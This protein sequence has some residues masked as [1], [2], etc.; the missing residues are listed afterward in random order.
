[1]SYKRENETHC[2]TIFDYLWETLLQKL[3]MGLRFWNYDRI[4]SVIRDIGSRIFYCFEISHVVSYY[5]TS[6]VNAYTEFYSV[7]HNIKYTVTYKM[8]F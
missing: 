5:L 6:T 2:V 3:G 8:K 1:M 7:Y 4:R